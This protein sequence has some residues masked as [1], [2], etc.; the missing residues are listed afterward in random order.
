LN[1][2]EEDI[3]LVIPFPKELKI[4]GENIK[5]KICKWKENKESAV[6]FTWDDNNWT[7]KKCS[8]IFEKYGYKCTFFINPGVYMSK[9]L[10]NDYKKVSD[11]GFEIGNHGLTHAR[12]DT[13]DVNKVI[14]EIEHAKNKLIEQYGY[15]HSFAYPF[16]LFS[17]L[18][19]EIVIKN[20]PFCRNFVK[21]NADVFAWSNDK[22]NTYESR[23][24]AIKNSHSK[25]SWL[26]FGGHGLDGNGYNP[27]PGYEL[28]SLLNYLSTKNVWVDTFAEVCNYYLAYQSSYMQYSAFQITINN[29][30]NYLH[31]IK[32]FGVKS[33]IVT[34][35]FES[36]K[37]IFFLSNNITPV[38]KNKL[39]SG[40]F[41]YLVNVDLL[42]S[43]KVEFQY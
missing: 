16:H 29:D 11:N 8:E 22:D 19:D 38:V 10:L 28:D 21:R 7:V 41:E 3:E 9:V 30:E 32:Q 39:P 33:C 43:N 25:N 31:Q 40:Y 18:S 5:V 14:L 6:S 12:I 13:M 27:I 24:N 26:I 17:K 36:Q 1:K 35:S 34:I 20:H 23:I 37:E 42:K 15:C 4:K 2:E